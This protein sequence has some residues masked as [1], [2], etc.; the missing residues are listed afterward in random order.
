[1]YTIEIRTARHTELK[2]FKWK[3]LQKYYFLIRH[4]NGNVICHSETYYNKADCHTTALRLKN[5]LGKATIVVKSF[6]GTCQ[7]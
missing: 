6:K 1:M 5:G 7:H 4:Y 2:L 3:R